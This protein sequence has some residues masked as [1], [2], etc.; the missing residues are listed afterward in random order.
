LLSEFVCERTNN[1]SNEGTT[2]AVAITYERTNYFSDLDE[3]TTQSKRLSSQ[4]PAIKIADKHI[5]YVAAR[6]QKYSL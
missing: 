4:Q 3:S 6:C 1:V 2:Q 5:N